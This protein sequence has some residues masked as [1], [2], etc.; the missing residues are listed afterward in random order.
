MGDLSAVGSGSGK[1]LPVLSC[2]TALL[3]PHCYFTASYPL[4]PCLFYL[5]LLPATPSCLPCL[6]SHLHM[7]TSP[8]AMQHPLLPVPSC[9]PTYFLTCTFLLVRILLAPRSPQPPRI[10]NRMEWMVS[11]GLSSWPVSCLYSSSLCLAIASLLS[12]LPTTYPSWH[13]KQP[14]DNGNNNLC[15]TGRDRKG[16]GQD[17]NVSL[18]LSEKQASSSSICPIC[19]PD[20]L[21]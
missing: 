8:A 15:L 20:I 12:S 14:N 2:P 16:L 18:T 11:P 6:L 9:L 5:P 4:L 7:P 13:E 19:S 1:E 17:E 10:W 21:S 3:S